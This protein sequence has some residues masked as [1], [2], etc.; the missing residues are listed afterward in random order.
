MNP[1]ESYYINQ[2]GSGLPG[3]QGIKYQK[4][5][6]FFNRMVASIGNIIKALAP[7]LGKRA[8]TSGI[9]LAQDVLAG[10]N[11]K[12]SA[13]SRL[14]EAGT[15]VADETLDLLKSRLQ[16]GSGYK[17]K[18]KACKRKRSYKKAKKSKIYNFLK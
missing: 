11:V 9:N 16:K 4:G 12:K 5:H 6:G 8:L 15:G 7:R 10:E 17:R 1:Y 18:R 3:F 14:K 2:V 13:L